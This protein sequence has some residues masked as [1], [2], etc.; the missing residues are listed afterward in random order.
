VEWIFPWHCR[1]LSSGQRP[2]FNASGGSH[3]KML[4]C[5]GD[6]EC[7]RKEFIEQYRE[8]YAKMAGGFSEK[9]P[10]QHS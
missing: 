9:K 3:R 6:W 10:F 8:S 2:Y 7:K 1:K 5:S 4:Y